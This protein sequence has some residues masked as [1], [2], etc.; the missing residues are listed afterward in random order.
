VPLAV[1]AVVVVV[2]AGCSGDARF[3]A[4]AASAVVVIVADDIDIDFNAVSSTGGAGLSVLARF[5]GDDRGALPFA[6]R[7]GGASVDDDDAT[8]ATTTSSSA[9]SS[10]PLRLRALRLKLTGSMK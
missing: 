5:D 3:V 8:S 1:V 10:S 4:D 7:G 2:G 9:T 6:A